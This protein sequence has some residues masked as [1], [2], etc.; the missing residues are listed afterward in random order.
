MT[1]PLPVEA[2]E[3]VE[4]KHANSERRD[5]IE[6]EPDELADDGDEGV[7]AD[8]TEVDEPPPKRGYKEPVDGDDDKKRATSI[9]NMEK[10]EKEFSDLKDKYFAEKIRSIDEEI[11]KIKD[12]SHE[13][14]LAKAKDLEEQKM[15]KLRK[16]DQWKNYQLQSIL[17]IYEADCRQA[18]EEYEVDKDS[19]AH[20]MIA[21]LQEKHKKLYDEKQ[22]LNLTSGEAKPVTRSLRRRHKESQTRD[23]RRRLNPPQIDYHL[24]SA[25]I[26]EDLHLI[27]KKNVLNKRQLE[28]LLYP[29]AFVKKDILHYRQKIFKRGHKV[30]VLSKVTG[31][32]NFSGIIDHISAE[33]ITV[34]HIDGKS[35]ELSLSSIRNGDAVLVSPP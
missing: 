11:E 27:R 23:Q 19:I 15:K 25:D 7:D 26:I 10:I 9:D 3:E 30:D 32:S 6:S 8:F 5:S 34:S 20:D 12:K 31:I 1:D 22:S 21:A 24:P 14:L 18:E 29:D 4:A 16:A 35:S 33:T 2:S 13:G 28:E 17:T